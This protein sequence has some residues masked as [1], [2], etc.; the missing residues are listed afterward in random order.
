MIWVVV[1]PVA[2]FPCFSDP[3][4]FYQLID[5]EALKTASGGY[6]SHTQPFEV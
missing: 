6:N 1:S 3:Q 5:S 4:I 2:S